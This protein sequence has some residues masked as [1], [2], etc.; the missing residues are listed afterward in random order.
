M[1]M[2]Q[3]YMSMQDIQKVS[4]NILKKT[5]EICDKQGIKY[6]L[7]YGTLIGAIR[8]KGYIPWDDDVDL[9]MMRPDYEKFL[10]YYAEHKEEFGC[11]E[12]MNMDNNPKY[13]YMIT[14]VSDS[15][16]TI[17][18]KNE[19]DCGLGIFIDIYPID[20]IGNS[21]EEAK[22]LLIKSCKYPSSIFLATRKYYHFGITKTWKKR[23][24]KVP[25]FI[26]THIMGKNYFVKKLNAL[27]ADLDYDHSEYVGCP[28][29]TNFPYIDV[30]RKEWFEDLIKVPF[31]DGE[32]YAPREY[33]KV[34]RIT[35][36]DYMQLPPEKDR[37]YHHMYRAYKR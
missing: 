25:A 7:A 21:E 26:Y 28:A 6:C 2:S 14:R 31:E 19:R 33:D 15:R 20:G 34:L 22:A 1:N 37:I 5:A 17:K 9:M 12:V 13:P 10:K 27:L 4:L 35:Y 32:F 23:L 36:G 3:Q 8:H 30:Y 16:Y 29:W 24:I 11:L 18:V